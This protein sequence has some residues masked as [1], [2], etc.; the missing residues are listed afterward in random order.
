MLQKI[1]F[2]LF[3][4]TMAVSYAAHGQMHTGENTGKN[5]WENSGDYAGENPDTSKVYRKI[6]HFSDKS[7]FTKFIHKFIFKPLPPKVKPRKVKQRKTPVQ[8]ASTHFDG[9]IIRRINITTFDPFGYSIHDTAARPHG[10]IANTGNHIH[11]STL[12]LTIRNLLLIHK[13]APYDYLAAK[14]SERLIRSQ[15]Y[16]REVI[17]RPVII[18][19]ERDSVDVDIMVLD[20]WSMIPSAIVSSSRIKIGLIENNFIGTGHQFQNKFGWNHVTGLSTYEGKYFIPNIK[21]TYVNT[22]LEY[23]KDEQKN[24]TRSWTVERP[25]FSSFAKWAG[26]AYFGQQLHKDSIAFPDSTHILQNFKF[27]TQD[28]WAGKAWR[29]F[30]GSTEDARTTNMIFTGRF[31]KVR[32]LEKPDLLYD[33]LHK[34][35]DERF[36]LS[37]I[38][39]SRRKYVHDKYI[40]SVGYTEDVPVGQ[41]IGLTG[42]YQVKDD[43]ARWYTGMKISWGNYYSWGYFSPNVELGGFLKSSRFEEVTL[44]AELNY[45]T[46]LFE[47]GDWKFR[48]FVKPMLILG[49]NRLA[50]DEL[51]VTG[52]LPG[53]NTTTIVGT[54]RLLLTLQTQAYAPLSLWGFKFGPYGNCTLG[55][56][57]NEASGF[58]SGRL[59]SQFGIGVL[60]RNEYLIFSTF[61]I[62]LAFY[63]R[64]PG[65]GDKFFRVNPYDAGS[66]G[67][68]DFDLQKPMTVIYQ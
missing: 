58:R 10:F 49:V 9:K 40:F 3:L 62:S 26:G 65:L 57:G 28:I 4:F 66:F 52:D 13:N 21:N 60:I 24:Y 20:I 41:V 16:V 32:Y 63:P 18:P 55:M 45:F 7:R 31:L 33:T 23:K 1:V 37:G 14:E 12:P 43:I 50:S 5:V 8:L 38:G 68:R 36:F 11:K 53:F 22:A 27:D 29:I 48:Q 6:E 35:T 2:F 59:Y 54:H 67:F 61:Q 44:R 34:Y 51:T 47:I 64:F 25:F 39:I 19:K 17:L 15:N 56:M 30:K 42:G 46:H